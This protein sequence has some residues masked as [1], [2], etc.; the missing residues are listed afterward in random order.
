MVVFSFL[1]C[2]KIETIES[3]S[4]YILFQSK[5]ILQLLKARIK[6]DK[7]TLILAAIY[8]HMQAPDVLVDA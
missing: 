3:L 1:C 4:L 8:V 5:N 2:F 7:N 6:Q